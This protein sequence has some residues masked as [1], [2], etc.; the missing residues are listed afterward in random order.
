MLH[1]NVFVI[2]QNDTLPVLKMQ[3]LDSSNNP[4]NLDLCGIVFIMANYKGEVVLTKQAEIVD[5]NA[6]IVQ[7]NWDANDT[8][9]VGDY[10]CEIKVSMPDGNRITIPTDEYIY[11]M[12]IEELSE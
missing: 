9:N 12:V 10:L 1:R 2:K 8:A 4:I 11:V 3:L 5:I 6:G 7:V